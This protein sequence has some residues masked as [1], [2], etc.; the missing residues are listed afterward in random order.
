MMRLTEHCEETSH[1]DPDFDR[2]RYCY[3]KSHGAS[4]RT[5]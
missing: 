1:N 3:T 2:C 5:R 4:T